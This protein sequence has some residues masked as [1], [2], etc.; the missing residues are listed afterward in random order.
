MC[1]DL[2]AFILQGGSGSDG[3]DGV[4]G[5][6]GLKVVKETQSAVLFKLCMICASLMFFF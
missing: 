3:S 2:K 5:K 1:S 6:P 4:P